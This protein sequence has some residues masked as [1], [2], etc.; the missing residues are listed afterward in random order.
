M[1]KEVVVRFVFDLFFFFPRKNGKI[2]VEL[3]EGFRCLASMLRKSCRIQRKIPAVP[4]A[5]MLFHEAY[6][7]G[8]DFRLN[9]RELYV[10]V[11]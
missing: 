2:F 11:A 7:G 3:K 10:K 8:C 4:R 6:G 1:L 5:F 9:W